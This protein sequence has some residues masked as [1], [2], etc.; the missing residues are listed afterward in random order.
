[1]RAATLAAHGHTGELK[2]ATL[3]V[4]ETVLEDM[5][6]RNAQRTL[7]AGSEA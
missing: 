7:L 6:H 5:Q 2:V 1:M 3:P 4:K